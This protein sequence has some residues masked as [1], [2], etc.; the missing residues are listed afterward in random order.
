MIT[1]EGREKAKKD[2]EQIV[3]NNDK[4]GLTELLFGRMDFIVKHEV[5]IAERKLNFENIKAVL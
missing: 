1:D 3:N 4:K 5:S 2:I